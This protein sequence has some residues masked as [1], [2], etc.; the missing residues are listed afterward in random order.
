MKVV[1]LEETK[2]EY[3]IE[4]FGV[5]Y[6]V[7]FDRLDELSIDIDEENTRENFKIK[8][9]IRDLE[10]LKREYESVVE[11][12]KYSIDEHDASCV[13]K[14][15]AICNTLDKTIEIIDRYYGEK[16][17]K[18]ELHSDDKAIEWIKNHSKDFA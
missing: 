9:V 4:N 10:N 2:E 5:P 16:K 18:T 6:G 7:S 8:F 14:L 13:K 12:L 15:I 1:C 11:H 3:D 17:E